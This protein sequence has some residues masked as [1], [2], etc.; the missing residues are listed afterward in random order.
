MSG[1][2]LRLPDAVTIGPLNNM[3]LMERKRVLRILEEKPT[4]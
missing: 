4:C 1:R 2:T 3:R